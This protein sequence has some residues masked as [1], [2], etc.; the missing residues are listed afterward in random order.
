MWILRRLVNEVEEG[1]AAGIAAFCLTEHHLGGFNTYCDPFLF[2]AYLAP[3]LERAHVAIHAVQLALHHPVR[4]A[5]QCNML[6]LLTRG[7][8]MIALA[9]GWPQ[10]IELSAYGVDSDLR[11][12][13][14]R[15]R[16][17]AMLRAWSWH[18]GGEAVDISTDWDRGFVGARLTPTSYRLPRPL[19]GRATLSE[20]TAV[21]LARLG[22]P[23][24]L[25]SVETSAAHV[26]AYRRTLEAA[27]HEDDVVRD[28]LAWLGFVDF[29]TLAATE[30]EARD[31]RDEASRQGVVGPI[32][33]NRPEGW[34]SDWAARQQ[35]QSEN[36]LAVTPEQLVERMLGFKGHGVNH[37]RVH[38]LSIP[39]SR[40]S[41]A[42]TFG[43]FLEEVLPHLDPEQLPPPARTIE[44]A[45]VETR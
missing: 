21:E 32:A 43:L 15:Q 27:G 24:V 30:Q 9:P 36:S 13:M 38:L 12:E 37:G 34:A 33:A 4:V 29:V 2:G 8:C 39:G 16:I 31:R 10:T 44:T 42:E 41:A 5:E 7:R 28:C 19:I 6:D 26:Y 40:E 22:W 23:A 18:D 20:E 45:G 1:E 17:D 35:R 11:V 14:T 3:R 25:G